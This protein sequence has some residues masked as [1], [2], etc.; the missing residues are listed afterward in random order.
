KA[1]ACKAD[2]EEFLQCLYDGSDVYFPF[3][4]FVKKR[5]E[6]FGKMHK[7]E[8]SYFELRTAYTRMKTPDTFLRYDPYGPFGQFASYSVE[9]RDRVRCI[10]A[11]NGIPMST[12]WSPKPY[13]YPIQ[14]AQFA[15]QH[16]SRYKTSTYLFYKFHV[17]YIGRWCFKIINTAIS[18][19]RIC[20]LY[21]F[22]F[23][24]GD[25]KPLWLAFYGKAMTKNIRQ[26]SSS[27]L[28]NFLVAVSWF[29]ENQDSDGGWSVPIERRVVNNRL[30]LSSGWHSAMAQ[31]QALSVLTRAYKQLND[32]IF[33]D[34]AG[35]ALKI[36]EMVSS[37]GGVLNKIFDNIWYEE[38]PTVPGTYVL[39]GFMYALIGLYDFS[40]TPSALAPKAKKLFNEGVRSLELILPLYDTGS[41]T[42]YDLRHITLK[43]APN[44]ARWDYHA[45]HIYLL[46]W[47]SGITN[48][49]FFSEV[50]DRWIDYAHG[51]KAKHN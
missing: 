8:Q 35:R 19:M 21:Y 25:A 37:E 5:F 12:Q 23:I 24:L 47:L 50:A 39:N 14:I 2:N 20:F 17:N 44:L 30:T 38:Y 48:I 1:I 36:F 26:Q 13:Y 11:K 33:L 22:S 29:V 28:E 16:Y 10:S 45:V 9:T 7:G 42:M 41:G 32:S 4:K 31:G 27:N 49:S 40:Q 34:I 6:V 51:K 46:K 18:F 15:L 43:M 3:E